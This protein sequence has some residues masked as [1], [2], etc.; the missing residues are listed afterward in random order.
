M[1]FLISTILARIS[2]LGCLLA[3]TGCSSLEYLAHTAGGHL[4]LM[5]ERQ[6]ITS[7]LQQPGVDSKTRDS[8]INA[9]NIR[10]YASSTL[11][12]P[13]NKSYTQYVELD[14]DYV[15]W[16]VFAAPEL[17]L[18]PI[19]WCFWIV[20]C[21]P[22]RGYFEHDKALGFAEQM[23]AKGL[24]IYI[25]PVTAY[26]TL[27][28]FSDPLLSSMLQR[29]E[30]ST[31][32]TIFHELAHQQLYIKND[33]EFNEAFATAVARAGVRDWLRSSEKIELLARYENSIAQKNQLYSQIQQLRRQLKEIYAAS[34]SDN[35]KRAQKKIAIDE[36]RKTV[37]ATI[38]KWEH[39]NRYRAWVLEDMNNA[40]LNAIST[41]QELTAEFLALLEVCGN[42][43]R[44]FYQVVASMRKLDNQQRRAYL[45]ELK[46]KQ[47]DDANVVQ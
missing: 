46:C 30:V 4:E 2:L 21:V 32:D 43:Y 25:S 24:E 15:T 17:S 22:Y 18:Q 42:E 41:Y 39:G 6:P 13:E 44:K 19:S 37:D 34:T 28:W 26:S 27:G 12:L 9:Q 36:Y 31:A 11:S 40:K 1:K 35:D 20:G 10:N 7:V 8:L 5:S 45:S 16:V 47:I 29:G 23:S 33:T 14:R 38:S 3:F